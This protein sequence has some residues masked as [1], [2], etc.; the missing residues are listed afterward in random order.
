[1][2]AGIV[3]SLA[4]PFG[5]Y[6][7]PVFAYLIFAP[8]H[9]GNLPRWLVC[10]VPFAAWSCS[11]WLRLGLR[12]FVGMGNWLYEPAALAVAPM[13]L[14]LVGEWL[15]GPDESPR[16]SWWP[17]VLLMIVAAAG[18]CIAGYLM[19]PIGDWP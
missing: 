3:F 17:E 15:R 18:I 6:Y 4:V 11:L 14:M 1:V 10:V 8:T 12:K 19:P 16:E 5:I 7:V 9:H 13:M 2:F